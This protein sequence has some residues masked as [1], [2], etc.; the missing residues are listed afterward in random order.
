L[1][2]RAAEAAVSTRRA[3][4]SSVGKARQVL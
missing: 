4:V 1:K 2:Q 3:L